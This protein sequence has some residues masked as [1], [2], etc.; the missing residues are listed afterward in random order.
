MNKFYFLIK[1]LRLNQHL[2]ENSSLEEYKKVLEHHF[3]CIY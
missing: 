3:L 2:D 1:L